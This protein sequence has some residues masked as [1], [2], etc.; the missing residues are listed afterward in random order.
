MNTSFP[1]DLEIDS[2]Y[3][4]HLG[5][6]FEAAGI[7]IQ[8]HLNQAPGIYFKVD[9]PSEYEA[10]IVNGIKDGLSDRFPD[11]PPSAS[12]WIT[13]ISEH[14]VDSSQRAFYRAGR[15]AIEQAFSLCNLK[16]IHAEQGAAANP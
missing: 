14:P 2:R 15:L 4:Q 16:E 12:I 6:R 10:F 3:S 5:P 11:F 13:G 1:G 7:K 8:F 9:V